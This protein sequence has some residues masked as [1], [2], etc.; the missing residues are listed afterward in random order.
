MLNN[1]QGIFHAYGSNAGSAGPTII[2]A[3]TKIPKTNLPG[4]IGNEVQVQD[5]ILTTARASQDSRA[6]LEIADDNGSGSPGAFSEVAVLRTPDYGNAMRS[7]T[8]LIKIKQNQWFRVRFT[9][10]TV[11]AIEVELT[12]QTAAQDLKV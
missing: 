11:G 5:F 8:G 12:G 7:Y 2:I 3:Q 10:G 9:Q 1:P 6:V 4:D